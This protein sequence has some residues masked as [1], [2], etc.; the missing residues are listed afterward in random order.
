MK[1]QLVLFAFLIG[2]GLQA[3]NIPKITLKDSSELKLATLH[4]DV[5]VMG[6][7][8]TTTYKMK[9][10]N[11]SDQVLEGELAFPLGQ[12]QHVSEFAMDV[13]G[14]MRKAVI[15][16]KELARVAY[17]S[18]IRQKIDPGLLTQ[19]QGNNYKARIYPIPAKG[20]KEIKITHEQE[21]FMKDHAHF[22]ELPL[23]FKKTLDV[24]SVRIQVDD[25]LLQPSIESQK[26]SSSEFKEWE[27][28]YVLNM[29]Q[30]NYHP[31]ES[32][33]IKIPVSELKTKVFVDQNYFHIYK[34][35]RPDKRL[36]KKPKG[37][38]MLWDT[39]YSMRFRN[40][41]ME[42]SVLDAY[43]DYLQNVDIQLITFSNSI[44]T[45]SKFSVKDGNWGSLKSVISNCQY[46]G[47]TSFESLH[48]KEYRSD[49]YLLFS[50]GMVNLGDFKAGPKKKIYALNSLVSANH[51]K[52]EKY[53]LKSGGDYINLKRQ[54]IKSAVEA[55]K[56]EAFQFLGTSLDNTES[57]IY[58]KTRMNVTNDFS[59]AGK[60]SYELEKLT[61]LFGFGNKVTQKV[62]INLCEAVPSKLAQ[63]SWGQ[64]KLNYLVKNKEE[65]KGE[66]TVL[67]KKHQLISPYTSMLILDRVEDYVKYRIEPPKELKKQY[68]RLVKNLE[69]VNTIKLKE[70]AIRKK[71]LHNDFKN[72]RFWWKT[73]FKEKN[74]I[75]NT[76]RIGN[77]QNDT[78][79]NLTQGIRIPT[80]IDTTKR[81]IYGTILDIHNEPLPGVDV[82]LLGTNI[83]VQS[84]FDGNYWLNANSS[85]RLEFSY[86]GMHST[87][88]MIGSSDE[89]NVVL[90]E[91]SE[92]LEEVV[93][94]GY[95][96]IVNRKSMSYSV[97]TVTESLQ[98]QVSGLEISNAVGN[99]TNVVVRGIS[100]LNS[101]TEQL[102][103]VDGVPVDNYESIN[104][105]PND[106][107]TMSVL[108]S[109]EVQTLYGLRGANGIVLITT[110]AGS[111]NNQEAIEV[112]EKKISDKMTLK[113]W[114]PNAEYLKLL[115]KEKNSKDAYSKYIEIRPKYANVPTFF[116]DVADFFDKKKEN[117]IAI[118]ILTNLIEI[119][120]DDHELMRALA[121]KLEYFEKYD[122]ALHI[123]KEVLKLRPE[124]PH[125]YRDLA[126][127]YINVENYTVAYS[128]L[129][130]IV[131][132]ELLEKDEDERFYGIEHV[133]Y[134]ELNSLV[135]KYKKE[136]SNI[137]KDTIGYTTFP[138]D[139]RV[140]VDWNHNDTDIDLW[141]E[142]PNGEK[143][144]YGH[145]KTKLGARISEDMQEGYGPEEF[146]LKKAI[147]GEYKITLDYFSDTVQKISGPTSAKV[148]IFKNYG[149]PNQTSEI[150]VVRLTKE[151]EDNLFIGSIKI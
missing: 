126:L 5:S 58:P 31:K 12:G 62:E 142:D 110:K 28:S 79:R 55:L 121:Y 131:L 66:I 38:T 67:A 106:I 77:V 68:K 103:I 87:N 145:S 98:G 26:M 23:G 43:F 94:V 6:N 146:M 69:D 84:D 134:I 78:S 90:E 129:R 89:I 72:L 76:N 46:D 19:T 36:K 109:A 95:G 39:S 133:A 102:Y 122:L 85:D 2:L 136:I 120:L 64:K 88:L 91:N 3:Q 100:S 101:K 83:E 47:G 48:L 8:A 80:Y 63:R 117:E 149:R 99:T 123:Y 141:V 29:F 111:E 41:E 51:I 124:E 24:F 75:K 18:T 15:V 148:T 96:T 151:E 86:I 37:I 132:G 7:L 34:T 21:L 49:E 81:M 40:I 137:K 14:V 35:L 50:D 10:Y 9:F 13:N 65:N 112:L 32:L 119:K 150:V 104:I 135:S 4:I 115:S 127:A 114:K 82:V 53:C 57:E 52:L 16:E 125:S 11:P 25:Q 73:D 44:K 130:K 140:V 30:E 113:P 97:A 1:N 144:Y 20:F 60:F 74:R 59:L 92:E 118:M 56:N 107:L 33:I 143:C 105:E 27:K 61:L 138:V 54:T 70:I 108:K 116:I 45:T 128:L 93:V 71:E 147:K 22:F 42:I 139:I 17:E